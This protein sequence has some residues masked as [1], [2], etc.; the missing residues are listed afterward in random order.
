MTSLQYEDVEYRNNV[1][2]SL[3]KALGRAGEQKNLYENLLQAILQWNLLPLK[4]IIKKRF[5][6][7]T[8]MSVIPLY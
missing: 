3:A 2:K 1:G 4:V 5:I 8:D 7:R 6:Y